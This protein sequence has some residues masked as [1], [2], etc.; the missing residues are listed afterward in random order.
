M[1]DF[2]ANRAPLPDL[3]QEALSV[4]FDSDDHARADA[5][6]PGSFIYQKGSVFR[7]KGE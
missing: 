3:G 2:S 1:A 4:L 5:G 6:G 7:G